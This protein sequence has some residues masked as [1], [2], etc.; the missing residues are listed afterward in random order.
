V[1]S[2]KGGCLMEYKERTKL[3]QQ[4]QQINSTLSD[5]DAQKILDLLEKEVQKLEKKML[6]TLEIKEILEDWLEDEY[7]EDDIERIFH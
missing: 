7:E 2:G 4:I 5:G 3:K 1:L 6:I